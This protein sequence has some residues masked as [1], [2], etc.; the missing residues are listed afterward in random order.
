MS[1]TQAGYPL[2]FHK[3]RDGC[4]ELLS[5]IPADATLFPYKQR[6]TT[7]PKNDICNPLDKGTSDSQGAV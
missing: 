2:E 3:K 1:E 7:L 6:T 5:D 4:A